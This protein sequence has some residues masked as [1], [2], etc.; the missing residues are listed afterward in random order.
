MALL[1]DRPVSHSYGALSGLVMIDN[2]LI[3]V[4]TSEVHD[5]ESDVT[6]YPVED[7]SNITDNIRPKGLQLTLTCVVSNTPFGPIATQRSAQPPADECYQ[8]LLTVRRNR[9]LVTVRTSLGTFQDMAL[10]SLSIPRKSGGGDQLMF[11]VTFVHVVLVENI[12]DVRVATPAAI[13]PHSAGKA[14]APAPDGRFTVYVNPVRES[15]G[16]IWFDPDIDGWRQG[17]YAPFISV[18]VVDDGVGLATIGAGLNAQKLVTSNPNSNAW[19]LYKGRPV[20]ATL[21]QWQPPKFETDAVVKAF[22]KKAF[23]GNG[24]LFPGADPSLIQLVPGRVLSKQPSR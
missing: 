2:Y 11:T 3:D 9:G 21:A 6:D 4:A 22:L 19:S 1:P 7:G 5:Y 24:N 14:P 13:G 20:G 10:K 12:R 15:F 8:H 23:N 16:S 17:A 18:K